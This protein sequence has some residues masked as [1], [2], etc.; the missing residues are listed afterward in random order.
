M[1]QQVLDTAPGLADA[2]VLLKVHSAALCAQQKLNSPRHCFKNLILQHSTAQEGIS[3]ALAL[4]WTVR[5]AASV[6]LCQLHAV[7]VLCEQAGH[8]SASRTVA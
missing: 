2:V 4:L 5:R 6:C 1:L 3:H 8:S 7:C